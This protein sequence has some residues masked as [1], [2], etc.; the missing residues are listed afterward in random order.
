LKEL[1]P[2]FVAP[3]DSPELVFQK[4]G[5]CSRGPWRRPA[6]D[7]A[8]ADLSDASRFRNALDELGGLYAAFGQF[9][10]WRADLLRTDYLGRLRHI[11]VVIPPISRATFAEALPNELGAVG[12]SLTAGMHSEPCWN[13]MA[14]CAYRTEYQGRQIVVQLARDP[15]PD[16]AFEFFEKG[17][18]LIDEEKLAD[19]L[20]FR[21][22]AH[23]RE[24]MRLSDSPAR[25]RSY[26]EALH[27]IRETTLAQYPILISELSTAR[28]L[29]TE[30]VEGETLSSRIAQGSSEAVQRAAECAL[31]QI[32]MVAAIDGE[33]DPD[34][35]VITPAGRLVVR[36]ANRLLAIPAPLTHSCLKYLSAVLSSNAPAAAQTLVR[37]TF[38]SPALNLEARLLDE[39]SN[40][41]PELKVN[42]QFPASAAVFEGNWRALRRAGEGNPLFLDM[43]HRN[44]IAVGYWNAETAAAP[45]PAKD[46]IVEAQWPVLGRLLRTRLGEMANRETASDWFIGSGLLFFEVIR[47]MNRVAE[48]LR[49]NDLSLGVDLQGERN[50]A[51]AHR[52]IR[53]GIF[54]GMLLV[55][56]LASLRFASS[57]LGAVSWVFSIVAIITGFALFWFVSRFD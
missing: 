48:G 55:V 36:R 44:L 20:C 10:S 25:E 37:L 50:P 23:F 42:L 6:T 33:F 2:S 41:E 34:S 21:V 56:F 38:G 31:E 39:L 27:S 35:M 51:K 22:L 30:W 12:S 54:I 40:L 17:I 28:V 5:L 4:F 15:I 14:R 24:W 8:Y 43:M 13:T 46:Y 16:A 53:L 57:A 32:C 9:L 52:R 47:Q 19:A 18:G 11:K 3:H 29:C 1:I 49:E 7:P 45:A 26:L